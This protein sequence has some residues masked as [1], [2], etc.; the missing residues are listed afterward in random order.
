MPITPR[1]IKDA[2]T[3]TQHWQEGTSGAGGRWLDGFLHPRQSPKAAALAANPAWKAGVTAAVAADKFAKGVAAID[4]NEMAQHAT[5][6]GQSAYVSGTAARVAK[7]GRKI[8]KVIQA[9]SGLIDKVRAMPNAT[10][11]ERAARA[12]FWITEMHKLRGTF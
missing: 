5:D 8:A 12:A 10:I 2:T 1:K 11:A 6:V 9:E 4:E 7:F 3:A